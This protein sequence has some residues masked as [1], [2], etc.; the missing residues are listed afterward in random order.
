MFLNVDTKSVAKLIV[1][2]KHIFL[3]VVSSTHSGELDIQCRMV[4]M[5][6]NL[7]SSTEKVSHT[8]SIFFSHLVCLC[9]VNVGTTQL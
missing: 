2:I 1:S 6:V 5:C 9:K 8:A 7:R 4:Y 3:K